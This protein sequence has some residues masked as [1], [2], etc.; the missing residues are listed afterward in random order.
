MSSQSLLSLADS[1][2]SQ[3][4]TINRLLKAQTGRTRGKASVTTTATASLLASAEANSPPPPRPPPSLFRS[5]SSI[6]SGAFVVTLS[7]PED[8]DYVA[9]LASPPAVSF[10]QV[11]TPALCTIDGCGRPRKYRC[12]GAF[13]RG[14]CGL[15]H[16]RIAQAGV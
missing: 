8:P 10:P 1:F 2:C 5:I 13:E 3:I 16:L 15:E 11:P 4:E 6:R 9:K 14:G 12:V 7:A